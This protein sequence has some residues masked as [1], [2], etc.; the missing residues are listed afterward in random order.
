MT[1]TTGLFFLLQKR[2]K[3]QGAEIDFREMSDKRRSH[4]H[5]KGV[6][7]TIITFVATAMCERRHCL[8]RVPLNYLEAE[9]T[10]LRPALVRV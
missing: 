4:I 3:D 5:V 7:V 10:R 6:F 2:D 1:M 8:S 9:R